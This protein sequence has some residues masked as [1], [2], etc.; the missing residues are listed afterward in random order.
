[1]KVQLKFKNK[2]YEDYLIDENGIIY[3]LNGNVQKTYL[4]GDR[5]FFKRVPIHRY[6]MHSF[7]GDHEGMDIHHLNENKFDNRLCNL[8][9]LSSS[10]HMSLHRSGK[11]PWN[12]GIK[13]DEEFRKKV[14]EA[15]LGKK[16]TEE[17][18][19]KISEAQKGKKLSD[20]H[21]KHLSESQKGNT[22]ARGRV[23]VNNGVENKFV[24]PDQIPEGFVRGVLRKL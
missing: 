10:E 22:I 9:Y 2:V 12:K 11:P 3:D 4:H 15:S 24:Y 8:V 16:L 21:I 6:V 14:S 7:I 18:K 19:K 13:M 5:P 1:M 23:W 17:H 20:D